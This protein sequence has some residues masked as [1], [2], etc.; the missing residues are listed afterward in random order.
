MLAA[1]I[2]N[3]LG[4]PFGFNFFPRS[5]PNP[6][7]RSGNRRTAFDNIY[8][9]AGWGSD[10][11]RSGPGS[12]LTRAR[13]YGHVLRETLREIGAKSL[14]DAPCGDLNWILPA[15]EGYRFIGGDIAPSL[16]AD[17]RRQF[18]RLDL[19]QFDICTDEFPDVDVW[20]CRDCLFHLPLNDGLAALRNFSVS[21]VRWALVTTHLARGPHRNLDIPVGGWR[22]L[23]LT[24]PPYSLPRPQRLLRD[25]R[26]LEFPRY[27]GLWSRE[28]VAAAVA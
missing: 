23:D 11:S 20:H 3:A 2:A 4:K 14:F 16:V 26:F 13:N 18:P 25:Y 9:L 1:R 7:A 27:V 28:Q 22:Y 15:V 5:F 10:E 21:P 17:L 24:K 8:R 6:A 12:E 19:R